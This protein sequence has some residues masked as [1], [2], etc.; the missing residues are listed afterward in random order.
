MGLVIFPHIGPGMTSRYD[1]DFLHREV[2]QIC[3]EEGIPCLDLFDA[4][5]V[6]S[7][8]YQEFWVNR[9]DPHPSSKANEMA[10]EKLLERFGPVWQQLNAKS[11][12]EKRQVATAG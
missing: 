11:L 2:R 5:A 8:R 3:M 9:F 1:Y 6:H 12:S 4:F 10:A 7:D